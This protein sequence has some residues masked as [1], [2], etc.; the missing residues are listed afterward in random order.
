MAT[1][2]HSIAVDTPGYGGSDPLPGQPSITGYA[3]AIWSA[4]DTVTNDQIDLFGY[5]T[6]SAIALEM[7]RVR[8]DRVHRIVLNSALMFNAQEREDLSRLFMERERR[9]PADRAAGFDAAWTAWRTLWRDLPDDE[10]AW[11]MFIET[12]RRSSGAA[13]GFF[14]AL[15]YDFARALESVPH[16]ITILNPSDDL[17]EITPRAES[18]LGLN[19]R[20]HPLPGWANGFLHAYPEEVAALLRAFLRPTQKTTNHHR[21]TS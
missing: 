16:P 14:A 19:A 10:M 1:D 4:V 21:E 12:Q 17:Q 15:S 13:A 7:A 18:A 6:G 2:R 3:K 8:P 11:P 9:R 20:I 5:H